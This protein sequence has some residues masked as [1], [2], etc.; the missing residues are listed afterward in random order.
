MRNRQIGRTVRFKCGWCEPCEG[1]SRT[2][3][4]APHSTHATSPVSM[5]EDAHKQ[6][7]VQACTCT[8]CQVRATRF[9]L[10]LVHQWRASGVVCMQGCLP[11]ALLVVCNRSDMQASRQ[12]STSNPQHYTPYYT[13]ATPA[14]T[15]STLVP[16]HIVSHAQRWIQDICSRP[17]LHLHRAAAGSTNRA[18]CSCCTR[19]NPHPACTSSAPT[20][21]GPT[22]MRPRQPTC[23]LHSTCGEV[24]PACLNHRCL[25]PHKQQMA[26]ASGELAHNALDTPL[27]SPPFVSSWQ[28]SL[29]PA[30]LSL[31]PQRPDSLNPTPLRPCHI[32]GRTCSHEQPEATKVAPPPRNALHS[33]MP[34]SKR[35]D[36]SPCRCSAAQHPLPLPKG[37]AAPAP[38][39][40][41]RSCQF[42]RLQVLV[43]MHGWRSCASRCS[44][45]TV[46]LLL[47][48]EGRSSLCSCI[49]GKEAASAS[50]GR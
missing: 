8:D 50:T 42:P 33:P 35:S 18:A 28:A 29:C 32:Q 44:K 39:Q 47:R 30:S 3:G 17:F 9:E 26:M 20:F 19:R 6:R 43:A 12:R 5:K 27:P 11:A 24:H 37:E 46:P 48:L 34:Q 15:P 10:S 31:Y 49:K 4:G 25:I 13:C 38:A 2:W 16:S 41:Q 7:Q 21:W 36:S 1:G 14:T 23:T 22:Q 40:K 45:V